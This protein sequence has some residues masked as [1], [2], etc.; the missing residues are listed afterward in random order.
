MI[1]RLATS[2]SISN[3]ARTI[4]RRS[5]F[6]A[7]LL[8]SV[9]AGQF[10][11]GQY[12]RPP[13]ASETTEEKVQRL[14]TAVEQAQEQIGAYQKQLQELQQ[15]LA[16]L[17]Q[18]LAVEKG[19]PSTPDPPAS[20]SAVA[21]SDPPA[22]A[23]ASSLDDVRERQAMDESQI[24][25]LDQSKVESSSKFPVKLSGLILF[26]A[27][28]NTRQVD[29]PPDPTYVLPGSG[30]TGFSLQ[31]TILGLDARGPHLFGAISHADVYVDFFANGSQY[32]YETG[33]LLRLRTAHATLN[34]PNTEAFVE[35]DRPLFRRMHLHRWLRQHNR[36]SHGAETCGSGTLKSGSHMRLR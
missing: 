33:S 36:S 26:N 18:Q 12:A 14:S 4:S 32:G 1:D 31:Q 21:D 30:S 13:A 35:L 34:W 17:R 28:V 7:A 8:S 3:L 11:I 25:T 27:F 9:L 10:A 2:T 20:Q 16:A 29:I 19:A 15:Q 5:A 22:N 6:A 23:S 24:A